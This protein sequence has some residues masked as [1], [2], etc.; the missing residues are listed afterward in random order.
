[1]IKIL[2]K[3]LKYNKKEILILF[4]LTTVVGFLV[5]I[6]FTNSFAFK[7]QIGGVKSM[8]NIPLNNIY[9]N[10]ITYVEN[11]ENAGS[12]INNFKSSINQKDN[13]YCGAYDE[14]GVYFEELKENNDFININK[15][16]Y[17]GTY[18]ESALGIAEVVFVDEK[19]LEI[20]NFNYDTKDFSLVERNNYICYPLFVS[21]YYKDILPIGKEL[22]LSR[23]KDKYIVKGYLNNEKWF[24]DSDPI[25]MPVQPF[26]NR[27]LTVFSEKD[28]I[29][30][31][32]Q[33]S[34]SGKIFIWTTVNSEC[35]ED[36]FKCIATN[37]G[38]KIKVSKVDKSIENWIV[39][40][41]KILKTNF[42][43]F[44][45]IFVCSIISIIS[46]L[47]VSIFLNR[48][49]IGIKIAFGNT[50]NQIICNICLQNVI[51]MFLSCIISYIIAYRWY[52]K[53][54]T[55][56]ELYIYTLET[57]SILFLVF[58]YTIMF[59]LVNIIPIV[60]L[61]KYQISDLVKEI[62]L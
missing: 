48:K 2:M 55:F 3:D 24:D 35:N 32:T 47:C 15:K 5:L 10:D 52:S 44:A 9:I 39:G 38:L 22:T 18:R 61:K 21:E 56:K 58:V 53:F 46:V 25:T 34:T 57:K 28:K 49:Q 51:V 30:N 36:S 8:F 59:L 33:Q 42:M 26:R 43:M 1:M 62:N 14:S 13:V 41:E 12:V 23:T 17:K 7:T 45:L 6:T 31:M 4:I 54:R 29:D 27:F 20:L 11:F 60:I 37:L 50:K 16:I 40:N 19:L